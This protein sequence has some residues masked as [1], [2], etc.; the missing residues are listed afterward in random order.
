M[1]TLPL[2]VIGVVLI[3]LATGTTISLP[4][5]LGVLILVG[6]AVNNG[7]VLI[8]YVNQLRRQG[9][10]KIDALVRAG[11]T[12]LRP[13]LITA[14]TTIFGLFPM[15]LSQ[16]EGSEIRIP[17]ALTVIG[18]LVT[19]TILSLFVLPVIYSIIDRTKIQIKGM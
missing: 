11:M 7:I 3:F 4:T 18:G 2:A 10:K 19:T 16:T 13:I 6:I 15:A 14:G 12:R 9:M 5:L 8:D 17:L 1:F